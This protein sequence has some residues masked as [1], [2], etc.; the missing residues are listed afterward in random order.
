LGKAKPLA[1]WLGAR[2]LVDTGRPV[3]LRK[4][5]LCKGTFKYRE[6]N[7]GATGTETFADMGGS[8]RQELLLAAA[9]DLVRRGEQVLI[10]L[11]DRASTVVCA[12]ILA[13]RVSLP[14]ASSALEDLQEQEQT[15]A[16]EALRMTLNSAVAF[17]SSDLAPDERRLVEK[18]FRKGEIRA[19][20]STTTLAMGMN[21]PVKNVILEG[22]KWYH[23]KKY[24]KWDR[25]DIEKSD[26]ENMSGR[27]GRLGLSNEF[28][29][30]IL[31]TD[32]PQRVDAI[33]G[34]FVDKDFGEIVPTL[35]G[36]PFEDLVIDLLASGMANSLTE[37]KQLLLSSFTGVT[38]WTVNMKEDELATNVNAA[39]AKC[40]DGNMATLKGDVLTITRLGK[41]CA[42]KGIGA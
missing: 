32:V 29:R 9:E 34:K 23:Y 26:Y 39:V 15:H 17:H 28:G 24:Q 8:L 25:V 2:L 37:M 42:A 13:E 40:V 31:V 4:G 35:K 20:F 38:D 6:H 22:K 27:A 5:V 36:A 7:S 30:S 18:Y 14:V 10:F 3:E 12:Q 16:Q 21:L 33:L 19:L 41:V 1:D 11:S